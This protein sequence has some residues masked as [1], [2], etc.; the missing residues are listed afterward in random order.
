LFTSRIQSLQSYYQITLAE[1]KRKTIRRKTEPRSASPGL[2]K[3]ICGS[4][5]LADWQV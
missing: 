3:T 5:E 4:E 2:S 1:A